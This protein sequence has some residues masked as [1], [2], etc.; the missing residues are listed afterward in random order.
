LNY[1]VHLISDFSILSQMFL[2]RVRLIVV[3]IG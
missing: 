2:G 3:N 1:R